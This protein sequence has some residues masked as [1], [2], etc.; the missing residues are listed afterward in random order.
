MTIEQWVAVF[1]IVGAVAIGIACLGLFLIVV[2][3][4]WCHG[5]LRLIDRLTF[6]WKR[7]RMVSEAIFHVT[8]G[9]KCCDESFKRALEEY[10]E[11]R[12]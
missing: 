7:W 2:P 9:C 6:G 10:R 1:N 4:I 12:E 3:W 11:A 8:H 5:A